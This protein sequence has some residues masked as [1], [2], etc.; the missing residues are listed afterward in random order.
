M[1][2]LEV[3]Q[4]CPTQWKALL[5][6][7]GGVDPSESNILTFDVDQSEPHLSHQLVFR[8]QVRVLGKNVF[9]TIVD[10][11][12]STCI[13]SISCWRSLGSTSLMTSFTILKAF[14]G[15]TFHP[16]GIIS[17]FSIDLEGRTIYIEVEV[18]DAPIDYI[19][20]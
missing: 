16:H 7:I 5:S 19:L 15:H 20:I 4:S 17:T 3:L 6:S 8:I 10:E 1:S 12:A 9:R 18:V 13:M 2:T 11:G 14:C